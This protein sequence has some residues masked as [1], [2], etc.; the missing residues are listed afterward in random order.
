MNLLGVAKRGHQGHLEHIAVDNKEVDLGKEAGLEKEVTQ[1]AFNQDTAAVLETKVNIL[2]NYEGELLGT[3][4]ILEH[5]LAVALELVKEVN[6][7]L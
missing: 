2:V 7:D 6:D 4:G 1:K 3:Q 5:R